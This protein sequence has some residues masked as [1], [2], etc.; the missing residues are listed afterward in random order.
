VPQP[1]Q[2]AP[3]P[4]RVSKAGRFGPQGI[5][6]RAGA[7]LLKAPIL[8]YRYSLSMLMGRGC[9]YL[10]TCSEYALEAIDR[11]GPW[12]GFWLTTARCIRCHPWTW[13]GGSSGHDPVP[14]IGHEQHRWT[15][16]RYGRWRLAPPGIR[17]RPPL[18]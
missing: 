8:I 9:R 1:E 15:P 14:D 3:D 11:N 6:S 13:L 12:R 4:E 2:P 7:V 17:T 5:L 10:P 16:W 18:S